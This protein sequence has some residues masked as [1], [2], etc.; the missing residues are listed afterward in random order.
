MRKTIGRLLLPQQELVTVLS[1]VQQVVNSRPLTYVG[2]D[3][4][5]SSKILTPNDL[6]G[7]KNPT[8]TSINDSNADADFQWGSLSRKEDLIA[9]YKRATKAMDSFWKTWH[10]DY[11]LSLRERTR[12]AHRDGKGC[13]RATPKIGTVVLVKEPMQPRCRWCYGV[14]TELIRSRDSQVRAVKVLQANKRT[15]ALPQ[16]R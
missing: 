12:F 14:V 2:G 7:L 4:D 13:V 1:E 3:F 8:I 11:L 15:L 5:E 6:L 9:S 10:D 16:P